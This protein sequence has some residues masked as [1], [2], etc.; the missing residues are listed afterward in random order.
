MDIVALAVVMGLVYL[1]NW[2]IGHRPFNLI[3]IGHL[4]RANKKS[5]YKAAN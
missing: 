5:R 4:I 3:R 2:Y 1:V